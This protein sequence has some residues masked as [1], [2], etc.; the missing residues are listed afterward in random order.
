MVAFGLGLLRSW[1]VSQKAQR[2]QK[3]FRLAAKIGHTEITES[4]EMV[5]FGLGLLRSWYVSQKAQR[6]QKWR[7]A[8]LGCFAALGCTY[9]C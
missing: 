3:G 4:T 9:G 7:P 6:A 8:A 5:A 2:A 1:Y